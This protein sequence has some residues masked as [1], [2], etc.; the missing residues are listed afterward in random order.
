MGT[1]LFLP[2]KPKDKMADIEVDVEVEVDVEPEVEVEVEVDCDA[3][4]E[5]DV[6]VEGGMEIDANVEQPMAVEVEVGGGAGGEFAVSN[7]PKECDCICCL[8]WWFAI[9]LILSALD[10]FWGIIAIFTARRLDYLFAGLGG[11]AFWGALFLIVH[12][13]CWK[14]R[15]KSSVEFE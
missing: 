5:V 1:Q 3:E 12:C 6:D 4:V 7:V 8:W 15:L 9:S 2:R 11:I 13:C 10:A 14:P